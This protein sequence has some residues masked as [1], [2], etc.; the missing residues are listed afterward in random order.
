MKIIVIR[1]PTLD[2][3]LNSPTGEVGRFLAKKGTKITAAAKA[4]VGV[5]TG[6]LRASIHMRH[7]RDTRG[8]HLKIGSNLSYARAHHE[9]TKPH[10]IRPNRAKMLRFVSRGDVVFAAA[11]KHPGT[12][13]NRYLTDNMRKFV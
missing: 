8:Q 7:V 3:Y 5:K 4:Q 2:R 11:V 1:E 12:R 9:G 13:A 6:G 10:I